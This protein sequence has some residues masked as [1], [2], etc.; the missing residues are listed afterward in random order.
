MNFTYDPVSNTNE[1]SGE[2]N[3][4]TPISWVTVASHHAFCSIAWRMI[5]WPTSESMR[6]HQLDAT[7]ISNKA[8]YLN[9]RVQK[10]TFAHKMLNIDQSLIK[11]GQSISL[12]KRNFLVAMVTMLV[13]MATKFKKFYFFHI[14]RKKSSS[15]WPGRWMIF[16]CE[17]TSGSV[18]LEKSILLIT[19]GPI[20]AKKE[21]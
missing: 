1:T 2:Q 3:K 14:Q 4:M 12:V 16:L 8:G 20:G 17:S 18:V 19:L 11:L 21:S 7:T 5:S 15:F 9:L 6:N 13:T 10:W